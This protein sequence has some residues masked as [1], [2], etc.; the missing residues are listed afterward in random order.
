MLPSPLFSVDILDSQISANH[1][2]AGRCQHENYHMIHI[3][4]IGN[5]VWRGWFWSN[6]SFKIKFNKTFLC[7]PRKGMYLM[8]HPEIEYLITQVMYESD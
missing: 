8:I 1:S 6:I 3:M 5:S 4:S 2:S 7:I